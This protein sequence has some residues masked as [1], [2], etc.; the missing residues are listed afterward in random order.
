MRQLTTN[1]GTKSK[2][3]NITYEDG[4]VEREINLYSSLLCWSLKPQ[5]MDNAI[6]FFFI[7]IHNSIYE[8]HC[9]KRGEE[10]VN[11]LSVEINMQKRMKHEQQ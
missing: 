1:V 8:E 4:C 2:A 11:S 6:Y 9:V 7:R 5:H 3:A 10:A